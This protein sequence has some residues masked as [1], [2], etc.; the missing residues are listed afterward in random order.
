[1]IE[2]KSVI[3][4]AE[5]QPG[6]SSS[7]VRFSADLDGTP[8]AVRSEQYESAQSSEQDARAPQPKRAASRTRDRGYSLRRTLFT[9]GIQKHNEERGSVMEMEPSSSRQQD[10]TF[11]KSSK[12]PTVITVEETRR[13]S[14][15]ASGSEIV[16][17]KYAAVRP[18]PLSQTKRLGVLHQIQA[19]IEDLQALFNRTVGPA[20]LPKT[21]DGRHV[22]VNVHEGNG[23][24]DERTGKPY[25]TNM[26]RSCKYTL[27]NFFPKQ[28]VAQF[29]KLANFYFLVIS[30][31]QMIPGLSTTGTFTTIV[32]LLIFV[33]V[34][35]AKEGYEDICRNRLDKEDNESLTLVLNSSA[36]SVEAKS[37]ETVRSDSPHW[38]KKKWQDLKVGDVVLLERDDAIP[39]DIVLI[40]ASGVEGAAQIETKSLDGETNLKSKKPLAAIS[41]RCPDETSIARLEADFVVEDPNLDLYKFD[42][43]VSLAGETIPLTSNEV[44]YRGSIVRNTPYAV[45]LVVYSGEECK[46]RMN[47]NK[48]PRVKAPTLQAKVNRVVVMVACLV[49]FIAAI[50]TIGYAI[51]QPRIESKSWYLI[52]A[53][54]PIGHVFTSFV[55]ML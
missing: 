37:A 13:N 3:G 27:W 55:I 8:S 44:I 11:A 39:A 10:S 24:T 14:S 40:Q 19:R 41:Q 49:F 9:Q 22:S 54:V 48:N 32:P 52:N 2:A 6:K 53:E 34:S 18:F 36:L 7:H 35:M 51:W 43:R 33:S 26:I 21:A 4:M 50:L 25:V 29:G 16:P 42:G 47:A 12:G 20:Q 38:S 45:G 23:P 15:S 28:L 5:N 17:A 46:I 31:L 1:M 30:I